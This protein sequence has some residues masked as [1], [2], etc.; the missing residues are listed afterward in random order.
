M[1]VDF[2]KLREE[3]LKIEKAGEIEKILKHDTAYNRFKETAEENPDLTAINYFGNKMTYKQVLSLIDTAAKGFACLGT[4]KNDVV[5][6]SMLPVPYG[7]VTFYALDKIGA[8]I[9]LVNCAANKDELSRELKNFKSDIFVGND[10]FCNNDTMSALK[11]L[12]VSK[13]ITISLTDAMPKTINADRIKYA[14]IERLKGLP[15]KKY[16]GNNII[17]FEQLLELGRKSNI[18]VPICEYEKGH[19]ATV[20]YTSG[21]TGTAKACVATWE[22]IDSMI[23]VMAM[24]EQ[25]RF[26][27]GDVMFTMIP[28]WIYYSL[29]NMVHEPLCLG[30]TISFDPLYNPKDMVKRNEQYHFNHWLTTPFY[31][32]KSITAA[33]DTDCSKWKIILTGAEPLKNEL[34]FK[35]DNYI[36]RNGGNTELV[37]G[38]GATEGLGSLLYCYY[39]NPSL[40]SVGKPCVGNFIKILDPET[41]EEVG[42][43]ESGIAYIYS[44]SLMKEYYNDA[45]ST[46]EALIKDENGAIWYNSGDYAWLNER[47]EMFFDDRVKRLVLTLDS[48]NNPTKISPARV[49]T[50]MENMDIIEKGELITIPDDKIVNKP[51]A[52]VKVKKGVAKNIQTKNSISD[53][54][55]DKIPEYMIPKEI[56]FV[57]SFPLNASSKVDLKKLEELYQ[58]NKL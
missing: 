10:I 35:T 22:G 9:H 19:M 32:E 13:I 14:L 8:T 6:M 1:N 57:D 11:E 16:D 45:Q 46:E 56:I 53:Y 42:P 21:S 38:Y 23:Q 26:E 30:V 33:K 27:K 37:Q 31:I 3:V 2:K 36:K 24:T 20:A 25:G 39:K 15:K 50:I 58:S 49:K 52:V 41:K 40:G 4:K 54:L 34:K 51:I 55:S 47:G 5:I 48:Q 44:P 7:I 12:N 17:N 29:I 18:D 43:N 28:L